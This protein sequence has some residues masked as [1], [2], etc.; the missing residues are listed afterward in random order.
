MLN[1]GPAG[2]AECR[3]SLA[4]NVLNRGRRRRRAATGVHENREHDHRS[5]E[6]LRGLPAH[7]CSVVRP[8]GAHVRSFGVR[9]RVS[10]CFRVLGCFHNPHYPGL[11]LVVR[12]RIPVV[13][14]PGSRCRPRIR[15]RRAGKGF[16][17]LRGAVH[18]VRGVRVRAWVAG[19]R[20][21]PRFGA[22]GPR[23]RRFGAC[24]PPRS[25][26]WSPNVR[27]LLFAGWGPF[28]SARGGCWGSVARWEALRH[29]L[30]MS[31]TL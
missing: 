4:V 25:H 23:L 22:F 28:G 9:A 31:W 5:P 20:I 27:D 30:G 11:F 18:R 1:R 16:R 6:P 17:A 10:R 15:T 14:V 19:R 29:A 21:C 7:V 13:S 24:P 8:C 12:A 2:P 3:R 26:G